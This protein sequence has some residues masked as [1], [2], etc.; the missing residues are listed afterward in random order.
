MAIGQA[1]LFIIFTMNGILIGFLFDIF[2]IL[3][4][5]FR[6]NDFMTYIED[7]IFWVLTGI[8][9]LFSMCKYC[10]GELRGFTIIG[11]GIGVIIY[12]LTVSKYIIKISVFI[13]KILKS[14]IKKIINMIVYPFKIILNIFKKIIFKPIAIICINIRKGITESA[15]KIYQNIKNVKKTQKV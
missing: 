14:I 9:I 8:I 1:N 4:K 3:R 5:S 10:D 2:R 13:I 11:I 12:L 15:R 6:T 7:I